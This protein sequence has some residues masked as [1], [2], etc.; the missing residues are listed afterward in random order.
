MPDEEGTVAVAEDTAA[1]VVEEQPE[2]TPPES[3]DDSAPET[4]DAPAPESAPGFSLSDVSDDDLFNDPRVADRIKSI[5]SEAESNRRKAEAAARERE[6]Q[7]AL[8]YD[9]VIQAI[10]R[11]RGE[12]GE[13][14]ASSVRAILGRVRSAAD[15]QNAV[16]LSEL[17]WEA[18]PAS[19]SIS[20]ELH[21]RRVKIVEDA[22]AGRISIEDFSR[23][24]F[25][26]AVEA[27]VESVERPKLRT[28]VEKEIRK[29]MAAK[30][31]T[32]RLQAAE[33]QSRR[34]EQPTDVKGQPGGA[35]PSNLGEAED[36]YINGKLS[37]AEYKK[38]R[39]RAGLEV[40]R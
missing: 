6:A 21:D 3:P 39:E 30:N 25:R 32:D 33:Q 18:I 20:K 36:A 28:Q 27:Y 9:N 31:Q 8:D 10:G 23:E 12:D 34:S 26:T 17:S 7:A 16:I 11:A 15:W 35:G 37:H 29:E 40:V 5:H 14:D 1:E 4:D 13:L 24:Q 38:F 19:A 2:E 22:Q